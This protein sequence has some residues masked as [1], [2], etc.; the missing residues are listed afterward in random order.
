LREEQLFM[1][2]LGVPPAREATVGTPRPR[3]RVPAPRFPPRNVS[4]PAVLLFAG[5]LAVW[6]VT[7][8]L[9][10][11]GRAPVW[12]TVPAHAV[13]TCTM[14]IVLH[15]SAHHSAGRLTWVNAAL[16][17][18]ATPFVAAYGAFPMVRAVHLEHHRHTNGGPADDPDGWATQGRW[19]Q[20]PARW[21]TLDFAYAR[22]YLARVQE[23][24]HAETTETMAM[25]TLGLGGFAA[26]LAT[27]HGG[28]LLLLYLIPQR[29]GLGLVAWWFAWLPHH[30]LPSGRER[31]DRFAATRMRVGLEWL[32]TPLLLSQNYH[33]VHHLHPTIPFHRYQRA[34]RDNRTAYLRHDGVRLATP[35]GRDLTAREYRERQG[36]EPGEPC[37]PLPGPEPPRRRAEFH[38]LTVTGV[39]ELTGEAVAVTLAVPR[40]L[41]ETFSFVPGQ[42]LTIRS[43]VDEDG[44]R[45]S[46]ALCG[47]P[48]T[49][50]LR[51]AVTHD[52]GTHAALR[53]GDTVEAMPPSGEFTLDFTLDP[54]PGTGR[55]YV[56]LAAGVGIAPILSILPSVLLA[57]PAS[58]ATLLYVNRS[59]ASTLFA[60]ELT[61]WARRFEGRLRVLHYRTDERDPDLHPVRSRPWDAIGEALAISFERYHSGKLDG[62]RTRTLMNGRL[63]PAKVDEWLLSG[64][65]SL[66]GRARN[67]LL[68][69]DVPEETV[70]C[71]LFQVD[72][73]TPVD[74]TH[75]AGAVR[76]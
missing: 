63:H 60:D 74:V 57:D 13:V 28:E 2:V 20:L 15:E 53:P 75:G 22:F 31:A 73:P 47:L 67:I 5:G 51:I 19:W 39:Q 68:E 3:P 55:H 23:R 24:P 36:T 9:A 52:R 59:G 25:L 65:A 6:A 46:Y 43:T 12:A 54:R 27:G 8:W 64:P 70:H 76:G 58:Q 41:H 34:W 71:A 30:G 21:L 50:T 42:Y 66:V 16:G 62:A 40:H 72:D 7:A 11:T 45:R 14:F 1:S 44:A 48:G 18:L 69:Y 61:G 35:W 56:A 49:G 26:A 17:R 4:P 37:A 29:I 38:P 32:L 33:L 10:L